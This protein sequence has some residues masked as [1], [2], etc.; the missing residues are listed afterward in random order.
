MAV[1]SQFYSETQAI[2]VYGSVTV[3]NTPQE[4]LQQISLLHQNQ[5]FPFRGTN[6]CEGGSSVSNGGGH[7][8]SPGF[9]GSLAALLEKQRQEIDLVLQL[10][11]ERLKTILI[12]ESKQQHD[13]LLQ[14]YHS[15]TTN[16]MRRKD[17]DLAIATKKTMELEEY[18]RGMEM[19]SQKWQRK[20][21]EN[22]AKVAELNNSLTQVRERA[23]EAESVCDFYP[24]R[25]NREENRNRGQETEES[26]AEQSNKS[27]D[28]KLC[29]SKRCCVVFLPCRHLCSCKSCEG[30]VGFCPVCNSAKEASMEVYLV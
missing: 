25:G 20:A 15:K 11:N 17:E 16:L 21:R 26:E 23:M 12:K 10:Q 24:N 7:F 2:P 1:E 9:S 22:E 5:G 29:F 6:F 13:I 19:E 4:N 8:A 30:F 27:V 28:C 14:R 18:L 3:M